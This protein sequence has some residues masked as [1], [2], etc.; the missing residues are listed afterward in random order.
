MESPR[1]NTLYAVVW[2]GMALIA[3]FAV[4]GR[5]P[6][7]T[8]EGVTVVLTDSKIRARNI[9]LLESCTEFAKFEYGGQRDIIY[10]TEEILELRRVC[11]EL[12]RTN[13]EYQKTRLIIIDKARRE[14][15]KL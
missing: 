2:I 4:C 10:T 13:S 15:G 11:T 8:S 14:R 1:N 3:L 12:A 5:K 7:I 9:V 6:S